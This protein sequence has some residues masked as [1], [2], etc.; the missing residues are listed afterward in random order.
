MTPSMLLLVSAAAN[1]VVMATPVDGQSAPVYEPPQPIALSA[2]PRPAVAAGL[3]ALAGIPAA[4]IT[5]TVHPGDDGQ[6]VYEFVANDAA[7]A[8]HVAGFTADGT[9][10]LL[11][12]DE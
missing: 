2:A 6:M 8:A 10:A 1:T 11:G 5:C 3:R 12:A 4:E 9:P 7:G